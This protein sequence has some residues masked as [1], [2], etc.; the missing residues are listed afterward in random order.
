MVGDLD[1]YLRESS[2]KRTPTPHAVRLL[3]QIIVLV[4]FRACRFEE[5]RL[6]KKWTRSALWPRTA[7]QATSISG[8]ETKSS[9][10]SNFCPEVLFDGFGLFATFLSRYADELDLETAHARLATQNADRND[11]RWQ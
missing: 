6:L 10:F 4:I 3:T 8:S 11:W 1:W 5:K 2:S 7:E 9:I